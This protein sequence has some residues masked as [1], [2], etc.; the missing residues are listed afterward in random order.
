VLHASDIAPEKP[1]L[2]TR[3]E[4]EH[5]VGEGF[6]GDDKVE[7]LEGVVIERSPQGPDHADPIDLLAEILIRALGDRA[8][9]RIQN[10]FAAS[11]RSEPEPDIAVVPPGRYKRAHPR[12][13]YLVIEVA[14]SSLKKDTG[15]KARIYAEAAVP[16]YW[17]IDVEAETV[18]VHTR[19]RDGAY[20]DKKTYAKGDRIAPGRF[21]D[22]A[23]PLDDLFAP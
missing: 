3:E 16:E 23:V 20:D 11:D 14:K 9:V 6:F 1:R 15:I 13:A 4:Y 22:V 2:V 12:E 7:L 21:P 17:V 5:L 8:R 19:P 10:A 18:A